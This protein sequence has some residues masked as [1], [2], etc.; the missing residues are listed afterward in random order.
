MTA[1]YL[2]FLP[3]YS[4]TTAPL[5]HLLKKEEP[6]NWTAACS[7]A[8]SSLKAQLTTPSSWPILT[9]PAPP[10]SPVMPQLERWGL[11][12]RRHKTASSGRALNPAEQRY[13]VGEREALACVWVCERWRLSLYSR[14]F[15][16]R[17]NHQALTTLL[18]ALGSGHRPLRLHRWGERLR[19]YDYQLKFTP[20]SGNV[21]A[22]LLSRSIDTSTPTISPATFEEEPEIIQLLH[23]PLQTVVSL[24]ELWRESEQDPL[25]STLRTYIRT[26]WPPRVPE[27]LAPF[28]RVL[29]K[30]SAGVTLCLQGPLHCG[31]KYPTCTYHG[32]GAQGSLE[33][34]QCQA[35]MPRPSVMARL[36][37]TPSTI[38]VLIFIFLGSLS[39]VTVCGNLLVIISIIYFKQLHTPTNSLILSLAVADLLVGLVVFPLSM[40]FSLS[41]CLHYE[42]LFCKVRD[43]FDVTLSTASILNLCCI[44]IYRYYAVCQPLTYR[45]KINGRVVVIMILVSWSASA[46]VTISLIVHD[47][48]QE[49][50]K[51]NCFLHVLL[52]NTF[53]IISSFY[54]PVI[55]VLSIYLKIFLVA[56]RQAH[57]IRNTT[58]QS[59]KSGTTISKNERK[60]TK[61]LAIVLGAFLMCWTPYMIVFS[62]KTLNP[63][64]VSVPLPLFETLNWLALSNSMLNPFIYAFFYSWFRSAFRMII[65]GKIFQGDFA[66]TKL[67]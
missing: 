67:L 60:A 53:G 31:P 24:D 39:V 42:H 52:I 7:E 34:S 46:S 37:S 8:F 10:L 19:Q 40:A 54:G 48:H 32:N 12:S 45:T 62:L 35:T 55:I 50:C 17:T 56:Q 18:S 29:H 33:D 22:D 44:S 36:T 20:G 27:D 28:A 65:S 1:Y 14:Q 6:W 2:R 58:C 25:L 43:S 41:S 51:E 4:Q 38:C 66:D 26:G 5:S 64:F 16:L 47:L 57:S 49:R 59:S 21:V 9:R 13:S 30:L 63:I 23:G 11:S 3:H 15:T 61:T